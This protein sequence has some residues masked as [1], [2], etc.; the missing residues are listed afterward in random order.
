MSCKHTKKIFNVWIAGSLSFIYLLCVPAFS[1]EDVKAKPSLSAPSNL[2]DAIVIAPTQDY[3]MNIAKPAA[4]A[5][6]ELQTKTLLELQKKIDDKIVLLT[7]LD[8]RNKNFETSQKEKAKVAQKGVIDI[9]SKMKPDVAA[10][11]LELID[12]DI[13]VAI[14][15]QLNVRVASAILNEMKSPNAAILTAAMADHAKV[16]QP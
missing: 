11:Q 13:A 8:Q 5:R 14:L 7:E 12:P 1:S 4:D 16:A 6:F 10:V 2:P 9:Y 3:C 15:S